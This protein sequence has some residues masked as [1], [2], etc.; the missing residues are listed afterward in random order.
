M[1]LKLGV[2]DFKTIRRI[3][4]LFKKQGNQSTSTKSAYYLLGAEKR[5]YLIQTPKAEYMFYT[6]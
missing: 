1:D 6:F 2:L 4:V 3:H 5:G